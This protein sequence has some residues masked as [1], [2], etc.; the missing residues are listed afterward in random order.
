MTPT[1]EEFLKKTV[2]WQR[3]SA[4]FLSIFWVILLVLLVFLIWE[5]SDYWDTGNNRYFW[6]EVTFFIVYFCYL[7]AIAW[8]NRL[9]YQSVKAIQAYLGSKD[10]I[11]LELAF[12][13]QRHFWMGITG[14]II[15]LPIVG[16]LLILADTFLFE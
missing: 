15:S 2:F 16:F 7:L 1:S 14:G 10:I 11:N 13:K 12:R 5:S 4:I 9:L 8:V 3:L 6:S